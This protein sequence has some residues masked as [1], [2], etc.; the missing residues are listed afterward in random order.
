M[1]STLLIEAFEDE[2]ARLR[3][4]TVVSLIPC[5]LKKLIGSLMK[6]ITLISDCRAFGK[7]ERQ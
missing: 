1:G 4:Q 7:C 2:E 5:L 3:N 6:C